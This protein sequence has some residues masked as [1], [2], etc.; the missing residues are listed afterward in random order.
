M[1]VIYSYKR[2]LQNEK[3]LS[4]SFWDVAR[5]SVLYANRYY[6]TILYCDS[7]TEKLFKSNDIPIK[8]FINVKEIENYKGVIYPMP[9]I[10]GILEHCK[11]YPNE[12]FYHIDLDTVLINKL[13]EPKE[14]FAFSHP[15]INLKKRTT[16]TVIKFLTKAYIEPYNR[17]ELH[18]Q[19]GDYDFSFIPNYNII[20]MKNTKLA[21]YYWRTLLNIIEKNEVLISDT[22]GDI[23]EAGVSQLL[24]QYTFYHLLKEDKIDVGIYSKMGNFDFHDG[25]VRISNDVIPINKVTI[26]QLNKFDYLHLSSY[27]VFKETTYSILNLLLEEFEINLK[28]DSTK[29]QL[30]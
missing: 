9:K 19:I 28:E 29:K 14:S 8:Q 24:E 5:V 30:V 13:T 6:N 16:P 20:Y 10:Y 15:E 23:L 11:L 25:H 2:V 7:A 4:K 21:D 12:P 18:K 27:D 3:E 17:L 26:N 22:L 1:N